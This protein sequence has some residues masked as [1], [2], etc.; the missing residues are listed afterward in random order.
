MKCTDYELGK[1][2]SEGVTR[3]LGRLKDTSRELCHKLSRKAT[4]NERGLESQAPWI[5]YRQLEGNGVT[6]IRERLKEMS[7]ELC[8]KLI[9]KD[10]GNQLEMLQTTSEEKC[11]KLIREA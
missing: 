8:H 1:S 9:G 6:S 4:G 2:C 7:G 10:T 5:G 3:L 11:H